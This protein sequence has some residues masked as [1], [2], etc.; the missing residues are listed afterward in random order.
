[1]AGVYLLS[2][3]SQMKNTILDD[4]EKYLRPEVGVKV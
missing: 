2:S 3:K 4:N 1:M